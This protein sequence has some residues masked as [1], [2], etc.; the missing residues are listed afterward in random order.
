MYP[1]TIGTYRQHRN[2]QCVHCGHIGFDSRFPD[3]PVRHPN[4]CCH[5]A[6]AGRTM[7]TST[8]QRPAPTGKAA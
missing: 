8:A 7:S 6:T 3:E 2:A 5:C 4:V 1:S